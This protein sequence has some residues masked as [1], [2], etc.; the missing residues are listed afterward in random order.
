MT[1]SNGTINNGGSNGGGGGDAVWGSITGNLSNQTDLQ[2][3]LNNKQNLITPSTNLY[4]NQLGLQSIEYN[5]TDLAISNVVTINLTNISPT[6]ILFIQTNGV[7][8]TVNVTLPDVSELSQDNGMTFNFYNLSNSNITFYNSSGSLEGLPMSPSLVFVF[9]EFA[10]DWNITRFTTQEYVVNN[11]ATIIDLENRMPIEILSI[12]QNANNLIDT[13]IYLSGANLSLTNAPTNSG[14]WQLWVYA[15]NGYIKQWYSTPN[16]SLWYRSSDITGSWVGVTWYRLA[17]NDDVNNILTQGANITGITTQLSSSANTMSAS[18]NN[19]TSATAS[20]VNSISLNS[21]NNSLISTVNGIT[22]TGVAIINSNALSLNGT[23]LKSTVNGIDSNTISIQ[24]LISNAVLDNVVSMDVTGKVQN[25]GFQFNNVNPFINALSTQ[26][27]DTLSTKNYIDNA[28]SNALPKQSAVLLFT[29]NQTLSGLPTQSGYTCIDNDRV[30]CNGQTNQAENLIYNVHSGAWTIASD[31]LT[32]D[33]LKNGYITITKGIYA[34]EYWQVYAITPTSG[35]VSPTSVSWTNVGNSASYNAG[36]GLSLIGNTF[37]VANTTVTAGTFGATNKTLNAT[38]NAQGQLTSLTANDI[39]LPVSQL[40]GSGNLTEATSS[41]L[42]ITGGT[43]SVLNNTTIQVKQANTSESGYISNTDWNTFNNKLS[44]TLNSGNVFAGNVSNVAVPITYAQLNTNIAINSNIQYVTPNGNNSDNGFT[45]NTGVATL[46]QALTNLGNTA[47]IIFISPKVGGYSGNYTI[48]AQNM[49]IVSLSTN[50]SVDFTGTLTFAHTGSNIQLNNIYADTIIHNNAGNLY[51]VGGGVITSLVSS[52]TG[53]L[54]TNNSDLQSSNATISITGAKSVT[55]CSNT[56][57]GTVT[58]NNISA[59]V[60]MLNCS[61]SKTINLSAGLLGINNT[62]VYSA[63]AGSNAI[64]VS[65]GAILYGTNSTFMVTGT[66]N[67]ALI[68]ISSGSFYS[69]NNC[70]YN[71]SSTITGTMLSRTGNFDAI[72]LKTALPILSGGTGQTTA[73]SSMNALAGSV[74]S[75]QYLRGNGTNVVMSAIQSSDVPTLNQNTTGSSGSVS[76]TNVIT[77]SNLAQMVSNTIKGNNTGSTTSPIDLTATQV[78]AMLNNFVGDTGSG[79]TKG[80]TPAPS[81]GDSA[82]GKFLKADGTWAIPSGSGTSA[83]YFRSYNTGATNKTALQTITGTGTI[84]WLTLATTSQRIILNGNTQQAGGFINSTVD[85]TIPNTGVYELNYVVTVSVGGLTNREVWIQLVR[86]RGGTST[87]LSASSELNGSTDNNGIITISLTDSFVAGDIVDFRL[88]TVAGTPSIS[89]AAYSLSIINYSVPSTTAVTN[90]SVT[91]SNGT[92]VTVTNPTTTPNIVINPIITPTITT[93][94]GQTITLTSSSN[95]VQQA[96]G[97]ANITYQL[98]VGTTLTVG[99]TFTITNLSTGILTVNDGSGV[100]IIS[101]LSNNSNDF[102]IISN[103]TTA[104]IWSYNK[105]VSGNLALNTS[106]ILG[107][108]FLQLTLTSGRGLLVQSR[109]GSNITFQGEGNTFYG[110]NQT[111]FTNDDNNV[112][113]TS[114]AFTYVL[115]WS[116]TTNANNTLRQFLY[117]VTNKKIYNIFA[118]FTTTTNVISA[119][120]LN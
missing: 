54:Q 12:Q 75:G 99:T 94:S 32:V 60:S 105:K 61:N 28:V 88:D 87:V 7:S 84:N 83:T 35:A 4:F 56:A 74:V 114:T 108:I 77:N 63:S 104:G 109:T 41:V 102:K 36:T 73:Q 86:T 5:L 57:L 119:E 89:V 85:I 93:S 46:D 40:T 78:T 90:V 29:S 66:T 16:D 24:P 30:V 112:I 25:A 17:T 69:I 39:S 31:S 26:S 100:A 79:G 44:T 14:N 22:S 91:N 101:I 68:N 59:I 27:A 62:T 47:G 116:G 43:N 95:L 19:G 53:Y 6:N 3:A 49:N 23:T 38:V 51:M 37:S 67:P 50:R 21:T 58:I 2:T 106:I 98:P 15:V 118:I 107:D 113:I 110:A 70:I 55:F 80:L 20:I 76:G 64:S 65:S 71:A 72:S 92:N 82:S 52:G 33:K 10:N 103:A 111:Y 97:S 11:F 120:L 115:A 13:G 48:L 42:T 1:I 8:Y 81:S 18:V 117:D 34:N 45:A 96:T 9:T